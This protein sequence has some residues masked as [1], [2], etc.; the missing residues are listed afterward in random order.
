MHLMHK[1]S[2]FEPPPLT[3][4]FIVWCMWNERI[5]IRVVQRGAGRTREAC[6]GYY[7]MSN[8]LS[9]LES[10]L[11]HLLW[12]WFLLSNICGIDKWMNINVIQT[13]VERARET[14]DRYYLMNANLSHLE[15]PLNHLLWLWF[16]LSNVCKN[17]WY[18]YIYTLRFDLNYLKQY[19]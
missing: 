10:P 14:S 9:H 4:I 5:N 2:W 18:K 17:E 1:R 15:S 8:N 7:L 19:Q 12:L 16:T 3:S 11:S 13:E 6:G